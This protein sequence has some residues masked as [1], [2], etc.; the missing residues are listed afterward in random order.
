MRN[1]ALGF[2]LTVVV[3]AG[4]GRGIGHAQEASDK[5]AAEAL[6]DEGRR[7]MAKGDYAHAC[8]K[9]EA[10]QKLDPGVGTMLNL[11]DCHEKNGKTASAWAQFREAISAAHQAGSFEREEIARTRA[12]DLEAKLSY[13]TIETWK[14]Q[15]VQV[16]RD[17]EP[18][19]AAVLGTAIPVD[20]GSHV[21]SASAAGKRSW[22]T[23]VKVGEAGDHVSVAVPI[24]PDGEPDSTGT[25][26][27]GGNS[28]TK[29]AVAAPSN[30]QRIVAVVVGGV[31]VVGL[32]IGTVFG[33]NAA[34]KWSDAKASC[35]HT[36]NDG[37]ADDAKSS[38]TISTIGFAV[39]IAGIAGG[40]ALWLTAPKSHSE[41]QATVSIGPGNVLVRGRF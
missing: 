10:S 39:G 18:I 4:G 38:A 13:L 9:L 12:H 36:C 30:T 32:G 19:D 14:G 22:S 8:P 11:A 37:L 5:A 1:R 33:L 24:L 15:T 27:S 2:A 34:S 21:I 41:A 31:G 7:L 20:P 6:F 3:L 23:T 26:A 29:D 28:G 40:L 35:D 25:F 17:D 16:T